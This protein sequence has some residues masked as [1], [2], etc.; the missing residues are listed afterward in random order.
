MQ[1]IFNLKQMK[2]DTK[3]IQSIKLLINEVVKILKG[4]LLE[5]TQQVSL[6]PCKMNAFLCS[7]G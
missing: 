5:A 6:N 4:I 3:I 1:I 7:Q 2:I